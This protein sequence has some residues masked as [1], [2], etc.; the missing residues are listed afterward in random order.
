M[1]GPIRY[2]LP[3]ILLASMLLPACN[4]VPIEGLEKS[5]QI[6]VEKSSGDE[7]VKIDFLW[8]VDNSTSMCEEQIQLAENFEQFTTKLSELFKLD[9]RLAVVSHDMTCTMES[10]NVQNAQGRFSTNPATTFPKSCQPKVVQ[11]CSVDA[12]CDGLDAS[13]FGNNDT[14]GEWSCQNAQSEFC[15]VNPNGSYNTE[16]HRHCSTDQ[17]CQEVFGDDLYTCQKQGGQKDWA[18]LLPPKT[19]DCPETLGPVLGANELPDFPCL[20]TIG[21]NQN[22]CFKYE[23]GLSSAMAALDRSGPNEEYLNPA[24]GV[25]QFLRDDAYLV[26]LFVTDED[27][28]SAACGNA[29]DSASNCPHSLCGKEK[30]D[31]GKW[32]CT[33][34]LVEDVYDTCALLGGQNEGGPLVP[35]SHY[36]NQIKSLKSDP[37]KV[38]V[39]AIAGDA[40]VPEGS[41]STQIQFER[42]ISGLA[43]GQN[44]CQRKCTDGDWSDVYGHCIPDSAS[45]CLIGEWSPPA[46]GETQGTCSPNADGQIDEVEAGTTSFPRCA[47]DVVDNTTPTNSVSACIADYCATEHDADVQAD[48]EARLRDVLKLSPETPLVLDPQNPTQ[49]DFDQLSS[50]LFGATCA[51]NCGESGTCDFESCV[52]CEVKPGN[53]DEQCVAP[54]PEELSVLNE[55]YREVIRESYNHSKGSP[56]TCFETTYVCESGS[57][58]A[59]WGSRYFELTERFGPSG[60]FTNICDNAGI[61]PAL[62]TI[63]EKIINVVNRMCLP[64]HIYE[65]GKIC[66]FSSDCQSG[67]CVAG[68]CATA[69][70]VLKVT[71]DPSTGEEVHTPLI[72]SDSGEDGTYQVIPGGCLET[73]TN[74][75]EV[76]RDAIVFGAPPEPGQFIEIKYKGT[77]VDL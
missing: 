72:E 53:A 60:I 26:I 25:A 31:D 2:A 71:R 64:I 57:G 70:E 21:V 55:V 51:A 74:G 46:D 33:G 15:E 34:A 36:T 17:E 62:E 37:S 24:T 45:D 29:G 35:I 22:K 69:L 73:D 43:L 11:R 65:Y 4:Q 67:E 6:E 8:V 48:T 75:N 38:I 18:C 10:H 52:D 59:D 61:G 49:A 28:C 30:D 76:F 58:R 5:L 14:N 47:D 77:P 54:S 7:A 42:V 56:Y 1:R 23:Q 12:D 68:T 27:D 9:P 3:A 13:K 16:C 32:R 40:I 44:G 20:A 50:I 19:T 39:A 66:E 63:A 41:A